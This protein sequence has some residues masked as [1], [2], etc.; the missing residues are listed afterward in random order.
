MSSSELSC[1]CNTG[2]V[3]TK[4]KKGG[5]PLLSSLARHG[6]V[7]TSTKKGDGEVFEEKRKE[8]DRKEVRKRSSEKKEKKEREGGCS[9]FARL[10]GTVR[11]VYS[12]AGGMALRDAW[13]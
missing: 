7:Y 6:S 8:M 3:Q 4:N 2:T 13:R 5:V 9:L 10:A 11:G 1:L 12:Q